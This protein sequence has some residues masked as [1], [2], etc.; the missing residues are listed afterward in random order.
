MPAETTEIPDQDTRLNDD[1][2]QHDQML[3]NAVL[4]G[5]IVEPAGADPKK[6]E[7]GP[8]VLVHVGGEEEGTFTRNWMPWVTSRS[9]YD[10]DW[11]KPEIDEQVLVLAP[12][13]NLKL[14]IVVGVLPR[15]NWLAFP[16]DNDFTAKAEP[17]NAI[18]Q[19]GEEHK[20]LRVYK[21]GAG[22]SYDREKHELELFL[23]R[24]TH[25]QEVSLKGNPEDEKPALS[26]SVLLEDKD[27]QLSLKFGDADSPK[28]SI[29]VSTENGVKVVVDENS[30]QFDKDCIKIAIGES[31]IECN[32]D[33]ETTFKCK[34]LTLDASDGFV[35]KSKNFNFDDSAEFQAKGSKITLTAG[36]TLEIGSSGAD[37]K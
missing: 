21:D 5:R 7:D 33:G 22:V 30:V 4:L 10:A 35:V 2:V 34:K 15:G 20:H 17:P 26:C 8:C 9:G 28:T 31:S 24:D 11:W 18:P 27:G 6:P 25:K 3:S 37:V 32:K 19:Q 16:E 36:T 14:G 12:S 29:D 1:V 23:N 13:G